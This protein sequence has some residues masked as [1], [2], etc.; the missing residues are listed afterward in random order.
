MLP[1]C[2]LIDIESSLAIV[3]PFS[4]AVPS[5]IKKNT[6]DCRDF[7][8]ASEE[9]CYKLLHDGFTTVFDRSVKDYACCYFE[10]DHPPERCL[11]SCSES[12][13]SYT[14][15]ADVFVWLLVELGDVFVD[16]AHDA[17]AYV[18]TRLLTLR[19]SCRH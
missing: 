11:L 14:S 16:A 15:V 12:Q 10:Q 17:A 7:S 1:I 9:E 2:L 6:D 18:C 5:A 8:S 4:L 13:F 19:P 3:L